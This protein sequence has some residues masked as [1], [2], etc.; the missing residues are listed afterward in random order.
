MRLPMSATVSIWHG[1]RAGPAALR[2]GRDALVR[3]SAAGGLVA[4]KIWVDIARVTGEI[5]QRKAN[6]IEVYA[7][8]HRGHVRVTI[9]D[10]ALSRIQVRHP[11]MEAGSLLDVIGIRRGEEINGM[12]PATAPQPAVHADQTE[13][14][15]R[16]GRTL[17]G[18]ATWF[19]R[20]DRTRG[21]AYPA[22]DPHGDGGGC[23]ASHAELPYLSIGSELHVRN[24]CT[25]LTERI[26]VIECGCLAARF[27]DRCVRCG[28]SPRGRIVEL[29]RTAFV[30]LGGELDAGC[31]NV[32]AQLDE[33]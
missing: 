15:H 29:T 24:D 3:P 26:P 6:V 12:R 33:R 20:A 17:R 11:R 23:G 2:T 10:C 13:P 22:L 31:F 25:G 18:T 16:G 14:E 32:T 1:T 30:D 19:E 4:E 8:P 27:C 7:G 21:A 5:T 9:P 28:T